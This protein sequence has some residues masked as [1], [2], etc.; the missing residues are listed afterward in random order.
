MNR[1]TV[2]H[3]LIEAVKQGNPQAFGKL[4]DRYAPVIYGVILKIV[5]DKKLSEDVLQKSFLQV[6]KEINGFN[7]TGERFL[8]WLLNIA[9]TS[10]QHV[11]STKPSKSTVETIHAAESAKSAEGNNL[12]YGHATT[13]MRNNETG[14]IAF[15]ATPAPKQEKAIDLIYFKGY[16]LV[17]AAEELGITIAALKMQIRTELKNSRGVQ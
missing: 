4:Y 13:A 5:T 10:A 15:S 1:N 12:V 14:S 9:K 3:E 7:P 6:R 2:D 17:R 11:I 16:S 8:T